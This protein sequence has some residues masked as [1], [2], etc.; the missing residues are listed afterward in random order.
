MYGYRAKIGLLVPEV[1]T[2]MEMDFHRFAPRGVSVH[3]SRVPYDE[4]EASV[5][6]LS[7]MVKNVTKAAKE[8]ARARVD[9]I[10]F[11]C[12]SASFFR[13]RGWDE[14]LIK[15]MTE[16]GGIPAITT[17]TAMLEA[18][19]T[20]NIQKLSVATPYPDEINEKLRV[21]LTDNGFQVKKIEGLLMKDVWDHAKVSSEIIY[22]LARRVNVPEAESVFI[23]CTQLRA[24][25]V[26]EELERDIQKPVV[27]AVQASLWMTL[28]KVGILDPLTG[29]GKLGLR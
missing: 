5:D 13:G 27:T 11:G 9:I 7:G 17:S 16:I 29:L 24:V 14:E 10:C 19:K 21:F 2:T 25:D 26:I 1:N 23:S 12:T 3:V 8:V 15:V 28:R 18:L 20:L 6:S 22:N 4:V